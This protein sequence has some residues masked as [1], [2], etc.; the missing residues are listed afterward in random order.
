MNGVLEPF[1]NPVHGERNEH[2]EAN[3]LSLAASARACI[4]SRIVARVVLDVDRYES[5][6]VP[7]TERGRHDATEQRDQVNMAEPLGDIDGSPQHQHG[8]R[9]SR[10]P[11][12]EAE[13][14]EDGEN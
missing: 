7:R 11:G 14:I 8:E 3:N 9:D 12:N 1:R 5:N 13:D 2:N 6:R 10:D 4:A